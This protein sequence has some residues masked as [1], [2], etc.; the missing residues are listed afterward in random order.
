MKS[1]LIENLYWLVWYCMTHR[2][3]LSQLSRMQNIADMNI[4]IDKN[5]PEHVVIDLYQLSW[6][7]NNADLNVLFDKT[8]PEHVVI[9]LSQLP[10]LPPLMNQ[11]LFDYNKL[12][13]NVAYLNLNKRKW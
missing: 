8:T 2:L 13:Q 5:T 9:Y 6:M 10:C 4:L 3:V 1:V 11:V 7:Q 12:K